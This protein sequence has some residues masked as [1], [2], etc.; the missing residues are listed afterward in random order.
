[1]LCKVI[2]YVFIFTQL[3]SLGPSVYS[4][5]NVTDTL[6]LPTESV[7]LTSLGLRT[8][9]FNLIGDYNVP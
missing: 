5:L 3:S 9:L 6:S 2:H 8:R 7:S 4:R 1:M